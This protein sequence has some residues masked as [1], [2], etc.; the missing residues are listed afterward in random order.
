MKTANAA[1]TPMVL[2]N[3]IPTTKR[4]RSAMITVMP[5]KTT[6]LPA[7]ATAVAADSSGVTPRANCVRC[8]DRMNSA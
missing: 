4:P 1:A 8:L 2:R 3:G 7:V 6:A 5:A